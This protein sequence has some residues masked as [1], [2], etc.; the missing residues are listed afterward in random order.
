MITFF[1]IE[2]NNPN[3]QSLINQIEYKVL[4]E[5]KKELNLSTCR[6]SN[7]QIFYTIKNNTNI[8][9]SKINEFKDSGIDI[10]DINDDFFTDICLSYSDSG[11]DLILEDRIKYIFQN[12]SLC[13]EG[14]TYNDIYLKNMTISCNCK[15]KD[16]ITTVISK[17]NFDEI[18]EISSINFDIAK[19]YNLVFS[20]KGKI[21]NIG[22][23]IFSI[24]LIAH[25]PFFVIY[26]K[27]GID[28]VKQYLFK[29]MAKYGYLKYVKNKII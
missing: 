8:D 21:N 9:V 24:I 29:E 17:I 20:L 26:F 27:K 22:F 2:L 6:D 18:E 15:I 7:I 5:Q 28:P 23:W 25:I 10:F 3:S 12:Y 4:N 13:E 11:N 19:C 1:Q 14:C 16:N